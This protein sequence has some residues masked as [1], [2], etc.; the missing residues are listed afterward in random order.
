MGTFLLTSDGFKNRHVG[1]VFAAL[2]GNPGTSRVLYFP[3]ASHLE[4]DRG[5][6]R[7]SL[8]EL[9]DVGCLDIRE[10][11][12]DH[13]FT[14]REFDGYNV[15]YVD[16]GNT[17]YLLRKMRECGFKE[18]LVPFLRH[19]GIYVG[20][21]AGSI[22]AGPDIGIAAPFDENDAGLTDMTGLQMVNAIVSPHF[23]RAEEPDIA[24][25][26]L[27]HPDLRVVRL[28]DGQA[29]LVRDGEEQVVG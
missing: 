18:A 24:R 20:V 8:Q 21:S 1:A 2:V 19:G 3:T 26:E 6:T 9:R 13:R 12:M 5:Y 17:F 28:P 14:P 16:G 7:Q 4:K 27:E 15:V 10:R 25:Y 23:T 22:V 11:E 29:L